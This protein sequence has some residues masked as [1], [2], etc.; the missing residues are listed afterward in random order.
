LKTQQIQL[1]ESVA[2]NS[3]S[4]PENFG[5]LI[6]EIVFRLSHPA[7]VASGERLIDNLRNIEIEDSIKWIRTL[8]EDHRIYLSDE[9]LIS[10][11]NFNTLSK[12]RDKISRS[13]MISE[14]LDFN[15]IDRYYDT[16]SMYRHIT[17]AHLI[18]YSIKGEV[19]SWDNSLYDEFGE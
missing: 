14:V 4:R 13:S 5:E 6:E 3:C 16:L 18:T 2:N 17:A 9:K 1:I 10:R 7:I 19:A 8:F 12:H 11:H 15:T